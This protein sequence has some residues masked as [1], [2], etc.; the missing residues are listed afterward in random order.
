MSETSRQGAIIHV[1]LS[2][3]IDMY[4]LFQYYGK[5]GLF[6]TTVIKKSAFNSAKDK[7]LAGVV[8]ILASVFV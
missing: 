6:D 1:K 4:I 8:R 2:C 3:R 5:L 7:L